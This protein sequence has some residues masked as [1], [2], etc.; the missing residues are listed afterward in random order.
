MLDHH[1]VDERET[2]AGAGLLRGEERVEDRLELLARDARAI[3]ADL[4]D[5]AVLCRAPDVEADVRARWALLDGVQ[6]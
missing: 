3:V 5:D 4:E 6:E 2:Q 1:L